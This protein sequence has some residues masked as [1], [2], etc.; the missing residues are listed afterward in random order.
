MHLSKLFATAIATSFVLGG[1]QGGEQKPAEQ[2][3]MVQA[4]APA[5]APEVEEPAGAPGTIKVTVKFEGTAPKAAKL[6]RKADPFCAKTVKEDPSV[7]VK[8]GKLMNVAVMLE[9]VKGTFTAP[10]AAVKIAQHECMYEPRV[11]TAM[12]GQKIEIHNDDTTLHNVHTYTGD[13]QANWFNKAQPPKSPSI[14]EVLSGEKMVTFKCDVHPWMAGYVGLAMNPFHGVAADG[15]LTLANV[16]SRTKAYKVVAWHEKFGK[17]E[18]DAVVTA[19][20][21]TEVTLTYKAT[22][23]AN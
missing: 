16:P 8:D 7:L 13:N 10:E 14:T 12:V 5:P 15:T 20:G 1:C 23:A 22:A 19:G 17:Q 2:A 21:T 18:A 11:Q 6:D 3:P 4:A 9:G